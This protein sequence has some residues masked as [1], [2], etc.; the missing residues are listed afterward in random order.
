MKLLVK[1]WWHSQEY[2]P[3]YFIFTRGTFYT[4]TR[5]TLLVETLI[6]EKPI[7]AHQ[8]GGHNPQKSTGYLKVSLRSINPF[9]SH[10]IWKGW[11]S[12]FKPNQICLS[13]QYA[14]VCLF[15]IRIHWNFVIIEYFTKSISWNIKKTVCS[16]ENNWL[17]TGKT[18]WLEYT[19]LKISHNNLNF[20]AI[21]F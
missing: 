19:L 7:T 17:L 14:C 8:H 2:F 15:T 3:R 21:I 20:E 18:E 12:F 16:K 11:K 1:V 10:S 6:K 13:I 4:L 5:K 9:V